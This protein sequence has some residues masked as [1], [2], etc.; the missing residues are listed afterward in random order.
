MDDSQRLDIHQ[1]TQHRFLQVQ[2]SK[3]AQVTLK[4]DHEM[5]AHSSLVKFIFVSCLN[6][7]NIQHVVGIFLTD[8]H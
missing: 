5:I 6:M 4:W 3:N 7:P 1:A 8:T 2:L